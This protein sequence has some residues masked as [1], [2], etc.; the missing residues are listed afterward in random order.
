MNKINNDLICP[1]DGS[2]ITQQLNKFLYFKKFKY[3]IISGIPCLY[4]DINNNNAIFYVYTKLNW[5]GNEFFSNT[6]IKINIPNP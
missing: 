6:T 1:I 4:T 3:P 2:G 5:M